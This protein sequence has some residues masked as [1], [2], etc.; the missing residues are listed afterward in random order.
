[1][2]WM[3]NLLSATGVAR[4]HTEGA[5]VPPETVGQ[6]QCVVALI[7]DKLA[8]NIHYEV[9]TKGRLD[10]MRAALQHDM[11]EH[12]TSDVSSLLKWRAGK[13]FTDLLERVEAESRA[14]HL[15]M[16]EIPLIPILDVVLHMGD[17]L[18]ALLWAARTA[19]MGNAY[20]KVICQRLIE[21]IEKL[22]AAYAVGSVELPSQLMTE[23]FDMVRQCLTIAFDS[24]H[25]N[26]LAGALEES[27]LTQTRSR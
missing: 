12:W 6:H 25:A 14:E 2:N 16:K 18:S 4:W 19:Y 20:G 9:G 3:F 27:W 26:A 11:G 1:M 5:L 21:R 7:C 10:L 13:T 15:G 17:L 23:F 24:F 8:E 22:I